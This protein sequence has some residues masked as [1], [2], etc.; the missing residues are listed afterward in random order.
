MRH[1]EEKLLTRNEYRS[2]WILLIV[3]FEYENLKQF[4]YIIVK[5]IQMDPMTIFLS[6][7]ST[8]L[9][10]GFHLDLSKRPHPVHQD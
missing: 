4:D 2:F 5:D 8:T 3:K 6:F 9:K 10:G 7:A 1:L